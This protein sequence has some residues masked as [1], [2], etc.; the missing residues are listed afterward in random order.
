VGVGPGGSALKQIELWGGNCSL[1]LGVEYANDDPC[2]MRENEGVFVRIK[3]VRRHF[4]R[5]SMKRCLNRD[6]HRRLV[7]SYPPR[8]RSF[9]LISAGGDTSTTHRNEGHRQSRSREG[10]KGSRP[11]SSEENPG[12]EGG[13]EGP[14]QGSCESDICRPEEKTGGKE[15][16]GET[17]TSHC[18]D[19]HRQSRSG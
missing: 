4:N 12:E 11:K 9:S 18:K 17:G 5:K 1:H 6:G 19:G 7:L 13:G 14:G 15:G 8:S 2:G 16:A 3:Q 10:G